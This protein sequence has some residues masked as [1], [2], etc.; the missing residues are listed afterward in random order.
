MKGG[1]VKPL[2]YGKSDNIE[3]LRVKGLL[4][5]SSLRRIAKAK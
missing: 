3:L 1:K 4:P 5:H 2:E